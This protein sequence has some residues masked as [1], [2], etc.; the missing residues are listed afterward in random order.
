[1]IRFNEFRYKDAIEPVG[2]AIQ[3]ERLLKWS[4]IINVRSLDCLG[5]KGRVDLITGCSC[6]GLEGHDYMGASRKGKLLL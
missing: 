1:M 2:S 3:I 6:A 4:W 5:G